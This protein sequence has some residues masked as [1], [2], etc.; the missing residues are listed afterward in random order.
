MVFASRS[1]TIFRDEWPVQLF[2][3]ANIACFVIGISSFDR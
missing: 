3:K 2:E 1:L